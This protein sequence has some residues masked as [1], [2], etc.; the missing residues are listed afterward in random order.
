METGQR[1]NRSD[2]SER[3]R[4]DLTMCFVFRQHKAVADV[5]QCNDNDDNGSYY[6]YVLLSEGDARRSLRSKLNT[7]RERAMCTRKCNKHVFTRRLDHRH[8]TCQNTIPWKRL[9]SAAAVPIFSTFPARVV[10]IAYPSSAGQ[11]SRRT[12]CRCFNDASPA[13]PHPSVG[14]PGTRPRRARH[15]AAAPRRPSRHAVHGPTPSRAA[16]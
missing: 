2:C 4:K 5:L 15:A 10:R 3:T 12:A 11:E 13:T 16:E 6:F 8:G 1:H 7:V 14:A 9:G